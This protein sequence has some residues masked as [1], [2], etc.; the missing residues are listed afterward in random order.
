MDAL[1]NPKPNGR[2][3]P[4]EELRLW[5]QWSIR[6]STGGNVRWGWTKTV[7]F[8]KKVWSFVVTN[9]SR[10]GGAT[11]GRV[12]TKRLGILE[13]LRLWSQWS[14]RSSAGGPCPVGFR[15]RQLHFQKNLYSQAEGNQD[16]LQGG[17][18]VRKRW[19]FVQS[20]ENIRKPEETVGKWGHCRKETQ[21]RLLET[22]GML[23]EQ[24]I[25]LEESRENIRKPEETVGT[26]GH[27]RK[28]TQLRLLETLGILKELWRQRRQFSKETI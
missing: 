16:S 24:N 4:V 19:R 10:N 27:C 2:Q 28:E 17:T 9:P 1:K 13:E 22:L 20:M 15:P 18:S 25:A 26:W 5:S 14:I 8:Q 11:S 21:S 23:K 3:C 7:A 6:S 12:W